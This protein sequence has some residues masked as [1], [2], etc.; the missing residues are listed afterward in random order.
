[1]FGRRS[2]DEAA[3]SVPRASALTR[4]LQSSSPPVH[5]DALVEAPA[6]A[7]DGGAAPPPA[8]PAPR[9]AGAHARSGAVAIS[10]LEPG[11]QAA[12]LQLGANSLHLGSNS[13]HLGAPRQR[14]APTAQRQGRP[15]CKRAPDRATA[16]H[17]PTLLWGG[18][19]VP[20][21]RLLLQ[22][23]PGQ[24][25]VGDGALHHAALADAPRPGNG[26]RRG[27]LALACAPC[28]R[29][30]RLEGAAGMQGP[31]SLTALLPTP[32]PAY[33]SAVTAAVEQGRAQGQ[34]GTHAHR[35][36]P[37]GTP[38][39][40]RALLDPS[41]SG[42]LGLRMSGPRLH[43]ALP[44]RGGAG[45]PPASGANTPV[46]VPEERGDGAEGYP[47]GARLGR[48]RLRPCAQ[49]RRGRMR[50]GCCAAGQA[51][52]HSG[53][54]RCLLTQ[55]TAHLGFCSALSRWWPRPTVHSL[56]DGALERRTI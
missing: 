35:P 4:G 18:R 49:T 3:G 28:C 31:H 5:A 7:S 52:P 40:E 36:T 55:V 25:R 23:G 17:A 27:P 10:R 34:G 30:L 24:G 54:C 43:M 45:G 15:G 26:G 53:P 9:N 6:A 46:A 21:H 38:P 39:S 29:M 22:Q 47:P 41:G 11:Q 32:P 2:V 16:V 12:S 19:H 13:L 44:A 33:P 56:T 48:P 14:L 20:T 51:C 1:M 8:A 37:P 42:N 50:C